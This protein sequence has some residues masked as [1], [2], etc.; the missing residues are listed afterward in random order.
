MLR[1]ILIGRDVSNSAE[2]G[3]ERKAGPKCSLLLSVEA[4]GGRGS[5]EGIKDATSARSQVLRSRRK[6][7]EQRPSRVAIR[8]IRPGLG[9]TAARCSRQA[10]MKDALTHHPPTALASAPHR[11]E[12]SWK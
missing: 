10:S 1:Y 12:R 4:V 2:R 3:K 11:C 9:T 8:S 6:Y 5:R 7:D